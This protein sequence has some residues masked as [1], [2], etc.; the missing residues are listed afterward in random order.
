MNGLVFPCGRYLCR[1]WRLKTRRFAN[2]LYFYCMYELK[3][4]HQPDVGTK[5]K[6]RESCSFILWTAFV[7]ARG[8]V[9]NYS[10]AWFISQYLDD[11]RSSVP[12]NHVSAAAGSCATAPRAPSLYVLQTITWSEMWHFYWS[13]YPAFLLVNVFKQKNH[14][15]KSKNHMIRKESRDVQSY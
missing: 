13:S 1:K 2:L 9:G 4:S 12:S 14:M 15:T 7:C 5:W 3:Y 11:L 10:R 8:F 6:G